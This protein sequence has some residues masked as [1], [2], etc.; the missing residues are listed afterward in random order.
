MNRSQ[1]EVLYK[2]A[3]DFADIQKSD[4]VLDL[5]C[6]TGTITL[7]MSQKCK[8]AIG[9]EIVSEAIKDAKQNAKLN[10]ISNAE[11]ICAC[12]SEIANKFADEKFKPEI[13][14]VDPPRK[15]LDTQTIN[16]IIKISP[17]KLVYISCDPATLARDLKILTEAGYSIKNAECIDMFPRTPHIET[18]VLLEK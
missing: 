1:A 3:I 15:G 4:T 8:M 16:S 17:E 10:N 9:V 6:G 14:C 18:A 11:F 13:I 2:T 5:Y 7:L 12:S